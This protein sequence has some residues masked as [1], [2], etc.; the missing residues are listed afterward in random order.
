MFSLTSGLFPLP[1]I[2]L[3][4]LCFGLSISAGIIL[5]F[6]SSKKLSGKPLD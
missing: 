5:L 1:E 2:L 3:V 6:T 4:F